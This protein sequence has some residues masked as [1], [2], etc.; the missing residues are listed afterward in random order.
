MIL[1]NII[2]LRLAR[3]PSASGGYESMPQIKKG[4]ENQNLL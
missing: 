3:K 2:Q 1:L 4:P